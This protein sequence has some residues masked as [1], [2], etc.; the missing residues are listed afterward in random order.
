MTQ[1]EKGAPEVPKM[2][3]GPFQHVGESKGF[4]VFETDDPVKLMYTAAQYVPFLS[5]AF[6]PLLENAKGVE[7]WKKAHR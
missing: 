6:V 3:F 2:I 4:T 5:G 7:I 1:R